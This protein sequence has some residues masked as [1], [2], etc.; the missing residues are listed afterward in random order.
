MG[1]FDTLVLQA[2]KELEPLAYGYT[3]SKYLSEHK[4]RTLSLWFH[5]SF[6]ALYVSLERLKQAG[7]IRCEWSKETYPERGDRR[8]LYWFTVTST[9]RS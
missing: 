5:L 8:R 4:P 9:E 3:I 1:K 2:I 6:G 7:L